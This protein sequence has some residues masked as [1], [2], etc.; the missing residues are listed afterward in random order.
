MVDK[1]TQARDAART[2]KRDTQLRA[3]ILRQYKVDAVNSD[4]TV[5]IETEA[6]VVPNVRRIASSALNAGDTVW[7]LRAG[8][9]ILIVDLVASN[10]GV[11]LGR[12]IAIERAGGSAHLDASDDDTRSWGRVGGPDNKEIAFYGDGDTSDSAGNIDY[13][14]PGGF[15]HFEEDV[16]ING[17]LILSP[18][19][20]AGPDQGEPV[21][22]FDTFRDFSIKRRGSDA[23]SANMSLESE[24]G[25][26]FWQVAHDGDLIIEFLDSSVN[27]YK[28][29][30][31]YDYLRILN[32]SSNPS[33]ELERTGGYES[34]K[35]LN[36]WLIMDSA[37]EAVGLNYYSADDVRL[38]QGG[39]SVLF[40][41]GNTFVNGGDFYFN[42]GRMLRMRQAT[43]TN[44]RLDIYYGSN[45]IIRHYVAGAEMNRI[46]FR[47]S[48][49][50]GY[51]EYSSYHK[52]GSEVRMRLEGYN[53]RTRFDGDVQCYDNFDVTGS[54]NAQLF[55]DKENDP[56][57]ALRF[58]ATE[59]NTPG[60]MEIYCGEHEVDTSR[61][62]TLRQEDF[63]GLI[64]P[65]YLEDYVKL[66]RNPRVRLD[67]AGPREDNAPHSPYAWAEWDLNDPRI[68]IRAPAGKYHVEL[69]F[70]RDDPPVQGW[71][72]EIEVPIEPE[73]EE[74][75]DNV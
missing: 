22:S 27:A 61:E 41:G 65:V 67:A 58:A 45:A 19:G 48:G 52:D 43:S 50:S 23:S 64:D 8:V 70:I 72:H 69:K 25:G 55:P 26:N 15:H 20:G 37:G 14:A 31:I 59:S 3:P 71:Q 13:R 75:P 1:T 4:G 5:D 34:I 74:E 30:K 66:G 24:V 60:I 28:L 35:S 33:L 21:I 62:L 46:Y 47:N 38:C 2:I 73:I 40:E 12:N 53:K 11:H 49:S 57:R 39:G 32:G 63:D 54:K 44:E 10:P 68:E 36:E 51:T 18:G 7:C 17:G 16:L 42:G 29:F 9:D 56:T 6:G